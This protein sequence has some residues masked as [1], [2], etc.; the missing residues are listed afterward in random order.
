MRNPSRWRLNQ[1]YAPSIGGGDSWFRSS[2]EKWRERLHGPRAEPDAMRTDDVGRLKIVRIRGEIAAVSDIAVGRSSPADRGGGEIH[3]I[4][5]DEDAFSRSCRVRRLFRAAPG[6]RP[7]RRARAKAP[8]LP[9]AS[10]DELHARVVSEPDAAKLR[11]ASPPRRSG[12]DGRLMI[13]IR[14]KPGNIVTAT[15]LSAEQRPQ[16]VRASS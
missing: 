3:V 8:Y 10:V 13:L 2:L 16:L 4:F 15:R 7:S 6:K 12:R 14:S 1:T 9:R 11:E 5:E